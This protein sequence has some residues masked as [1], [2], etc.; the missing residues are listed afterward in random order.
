MSTSIFDDKASKP[1]EDELRKVLA[2]SAEYWGAL[3][4]FLEDKYA[5]ITTEWKFYGKKSGWLLKVL[6]RK[7]NL[8]FFIPQDGY[9]QITFVFGDRAVEAVEKSDLPENLKST[10]RNAKKYMEG[11]GL[12]LEVRCA[13][14]L[15]HVK[16]LVE[17]K[18]K[19]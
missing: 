16:K 9:F 14:D 15:E 19:N 12:Q 2:A 7:R 6:R 8:F 5:P 1:D 4:T 11:R 3:K 13:A 10:L 17:I 18:I